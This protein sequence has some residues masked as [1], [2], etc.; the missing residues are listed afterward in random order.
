MKHLL[1]ID[2]ERGSREA[3]QA[4]FHD[5]YRVSVADSAAAGAEV[6]ARQPVD[7][8]LLDVIMPGTNGITFLEEAQLRYPG[9]PVIMVSASNAV[10]PVVE[11]IQRGAYDFVTKPFDVGEIR[12][13]VA[14]ALESRSLLRQVEVLHG[15]IDETFP[16]DGIVGASPAFARAL[17]EAR[18]AAATDA[19]VLITGE[20]G[21][22]KE[23]VAR[24]VHTHSPRAAEP[25]VPVHC[26]ALPE[27]LLES[28]LFGHEPGA[29]TNAI[30]QKP[31]RFDLAGSGTLFFD[32]VGEMTPATQV[33]LLRVLEQKEFMRVG[34]TRVIRTDARIVA[35]TN[36]DLKGAV[37][38]K[39]FREDLY[40]RLSVVPIHL[41]PL[42]ERPED[43][44]GLAEYFL[45]RFTQ[46]GAYRTRG[47]SPEAL[48]LLR[49]YA[50]PGNVREL[51]NVVERM[52]VLYGRHPLILA[53][54]LP[55]EFRPPGRT[56]PVVA[57]H[58]PLPLA[59]AV[60]NF[61]RRLVEDALRQANGIQ[62]RAAELLGTTRRILKYRME[63]LNIRG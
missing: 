56:L 27:G 30:R 45:R 21:T 34:G 41:P 12:R 25:F 48:L 44:P 1:I 43:I 6:L 9:L 5:R 59:E 2:D 14:R 51:R 52:L 13:L 3:L 28:E 33:K 17:R 11:S 62:T 37:A 54:H 15:Q 26:G 36:L 7:L 32:E 18:Q 19:T 10:R 24:L 58:E 38:N 55:E 29:F 46:A 47:F 61:E 42:R 35:A 31:G 49:G 16:V 40:Y 53:G 4:V 39:A 57:V 22:G 50:W 63:K 20:S 60:N 8:I 23:L